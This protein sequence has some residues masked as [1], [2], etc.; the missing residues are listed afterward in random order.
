MTAIRIFQLSAFLVVGAIWWLAVAAGG[1]S[2]SVLPPVQDVLRAMIALPGTPDFLPAVGATL[3][4]AMIALAI[5]SLLGISL[6]LFIGMSPRVEQAT[7]FLVDFGRSFPTVAL[8]PILLML[9]GATPQMK[10]TAICM[11]CVFPILLQSIYGARRLEA[12]IADTVSAFRLP[13]VL[14]FFRVILPAAS[15]FIFTG[16]RI[17]TVVSILIAVAIEIVSPTPGIGRE[18]SDASSFGRVDIALAYAAYAGIL[19]VL[20]N[21]AVNALERRLLGWHLRAGKE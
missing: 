21:L 18:L 13:P 19:G 11:G 2:E 6:G 14:T 1:V 16:F 3:R 5:S 9:L 7:R 12:T 10:I 20:A 4:D 8:L 17:A 15:P